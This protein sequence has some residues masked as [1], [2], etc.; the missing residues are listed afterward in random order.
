VEQL[1]TSSI[2]SVI[3]DAWYNQQV[4]FSDGERYFA[5]KRTSVPILQ[6]ILAA[7]LF[8]ASAPL[9]K[10]LLGEVSPV[11]LAALLY[12]GS[13][14][15]VA[16]IRLLQR[17]FS[18]MAVQEARIERADLP[19][20]AGAVLSGGVLAPILLL[21]SLEYTPAAI[22]SLLLNFEAVAT[23]LIAALLFKEAIGK[24]VGWAIVLVTL[25]GSLLSWQTNASWGFS[26]GALGVAT[27]CFLWG[28]DNNLTRNISA[29]DPL[30]IV[31]WKG[32]GAGLTS[33]LIALAL[34]QPFPSMWILAAALALGFFSFGFSIVLFIRAMRALGAARTSALFGAAP[35]MGAL[36]SVLL[37]WEWPGTAFLLA[38]P[39]M[40]AGAFLLIQ[41]HHEHTHTHAAFDHEHA[42]DHIDEHHDHEHP[43]SEPD[44]EGVHCHPHAH[45][46]IFHKHVHSP[47]IHHR[48]EHETKTKSLTD[49]Q[50]SVILRLIHK[51]I[52]YKGGRCH[53]ATRCAKAAPKY[54]SSA[55]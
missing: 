2:S 39:L 20:L 15:G 14:L 1:H 5:L 4:T 13:G 47:D 10:L 35:F 46:P 44:W 8:G 48:H 41:E 29:K 40:L 32:L 36:I 19:W 11:A 34:R 24:S 49:G 42:H 33:L 52:R 37:F 26:L 25:A 28:V 30:S 50:I 6:A 51:I 7:I 43:G 9:A 38:L 27:A 45:W 22:A 31:T 12:L 23:T 16:A 21:I 3:L 54:S 55:C 18:R 53:H 17:A